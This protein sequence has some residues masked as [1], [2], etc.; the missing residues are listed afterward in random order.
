MSQ[1]CN[2]IH[3]CS[4]KYYIVGTYD[5]QASTIHMQ[6]SAKKRQCLASI[7]EYCTHLSKI[8]V[9]L[10][11]IHNQRSVVIS[12]NTILT[13]TKGSK[14]CNKAV[15]L[16]ILKLYLD[17]RAEGIHTIM[18]FFTSPLCTKLPLLWKSNVYLKH[19]YSGIILQR[20]KL[21]TE[22]IRK[23]KKYK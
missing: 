2:R 19:Q 16:Q 23:Y 10:I 4:R 17:R 13:H 14:Y 1:A 18:Y 6:V 3:P 9:I 15:C 12:L 20:I 11:L 5:G 7:C 21:K 8:T 22:K